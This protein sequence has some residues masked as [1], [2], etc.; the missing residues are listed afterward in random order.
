MTSKVKKTGLV[1]LVSCAAAISAILLK[2]ASIV[3][4]LNDFTAK[5]LESSGVFNACDKE[6][7]SLKVKV[8]GNDGLQ[9]NGIQS[10]VTFSTKVA[11]EKADLKC[12]GL[13]PDESREVRTGVYSLNLSKAAGALVISNLKNLQTDE[14][15]PGVWVYQWVK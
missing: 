7:S 14:A 3:P 6:A 10:K 12:T 5:R 8:T 1:A 15:L 11:I 2:P 13:I 4:D 9:V